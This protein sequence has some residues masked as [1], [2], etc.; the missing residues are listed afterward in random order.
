MSNSLNARGYLVVRTKE[1]VDAYC[2]EQGITR[3]EFNV[4]VEIPT[5]VID[6]PG[7]F[8][9]CTSL[10]PEW[11]IVIPGNVKTD[12]R[13]IFSGCLGYYNEDS[14]HSVLNYNHVFNTNKPYTG[15]DGDT[16][17]CSEEEFEAHRHKLCLNNMI[18]E[19]MYCSTLTSEI[20]PEVS[21]L[22]ELFEVF[23]QRMSDINTFNTYWDNCD[24]VQGQASFFD[25]VGKNPKLVGEIDNSSASLNDLIVP[26]FAPDTEARKYIATMRKMKRIQ[27]SISQKPEREGRYEIPESVQKTLDTV[28]Q[29]DNKAITSFFD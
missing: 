20:A 24:K 8:E 11:G 16:L 28:T 22:R 3:A 29:G 19:D 7:L 18:P 4:P 2:A 26:T 6:C 14:R 27:K 17:I 1:D 9:G 5:D 12:V 15:D 23:K 13:G 25:S 21:S 10:N